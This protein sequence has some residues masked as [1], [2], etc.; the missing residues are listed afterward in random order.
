MDGYGHQTPALAESYLGSIKK[1][2]FMLDGSD[3]NPQVQA[4]SSPMANQMS[5]MLLTIYI[6]F[7][8]LFRLLIVRICSTLAIPS[9]AVS[10]YPRL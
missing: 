3:P 2:S 4:W 7:W 5:F 10:N 8:P 1:A 6:I 9:V